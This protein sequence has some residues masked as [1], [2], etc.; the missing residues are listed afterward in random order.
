[1][2]HERR[3]GGFVPF[4]AFLL[5]VSVSTAVPVS[6]EAQEAGSISG[7]AIVT[8][9]DFVVR[10]Q[11]LG[12]GG[13]VVAETTTDGEGRY[14]VGGLS[15]GVYH[16][17]FDDAVYGSF[18]RYLY[19]TSTRSR[20]YGDQVVVESGVTTSGIDYT[21]TAIG[22]GWI[23]GRA[24]DAATGAPVLVSAGIGTGLGPTE[25][26]GTY[27][28]SVRVGSHT[29]R[30]H[31]NRM[32]TYADQWWQGAG[33]ASLADAVVVGERQVVR[34]DGALVP[35]CQG[36]EGPH[37]LGLVD[38][39]T[40]IWHLVDCKAATMNSFYYGDQGD[41]PFMGD[42]NGDGIDT[43]GLYRQSDGHI[44]LRNTND[45]GNAHTSYFFG[46]PGDIPLAG[47]FNGDGF[48]TVSLYRP[49]T[50]TFHIVNT[51]G[52]NGAGLGA[53]ES[54]F[55][56]GDFGDRPNAG[57]WD[58]DGIDEVGVHRSSTRAFYWR[59]TLT[60]GLADGSYPFGFSGD[61]FVAGDWGSTGGRETPAGYHPLHT[62]FYLHQMMSGELV[63]E[64]A[65]TFGEQAWLPVAGVTNLD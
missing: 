49:A 46:N 55:V 38:P 37:S 47:D 27:R 56:F 40:G 59:N 6:A 8:G 33:D 1:M 42:W 58:G 53:A 24:Y 51:T 7:T 61:R 11:V 50:Q 21:Y 43:P 39:T 48:D 31:D 60:T 63:V 20:P 30:F 22:E 36:V 29:V 19:G 10:I 14:L 44:Y 2:A 12:V 3:L 4:A 5:L 54:S 15:P 23:E 25:L 28:W 64:R 9:T 62:Y 17:K 35:R 32:L 52:T 45:Q 26:D 41:M 65:S 34:A 13:Q 18:P 16:V 57:D